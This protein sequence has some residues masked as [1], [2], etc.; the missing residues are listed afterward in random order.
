MYKIFQFLNINKTIIDKRDIRALTL[1]NG[2]KI[3][4]VSDKN[5]INSSCSVAVNAGYLQDNINHQ[6]TAHFL[7]HL[8]FMG[9]ENFK[10]KNEFH[11]YIQSCNGME[12][13][14][15]S[16]NTTCYFI[17]LNS[18]FLEKGI[19]ML[20]CFFKKPMFYEECIKS[21]YNIINSEHQKNILSDSWICDNLFKQF[22]KKSLKYKNFGTGNH[23]SLKNTTQK[24][25]FEYFNRY[26]TTDN[27]NVCI[28]DSKNIEE[29]I[30]LYVPYFNFQNKNKT[31]NIQKQKLDLINDNLLIYKS[32][33][34]F[35]IINF[36]FIFEYDKNDY[37]LLTFINYLLSAN[38]NNSLNDC[39][40]NQ[41]LILNLNSNIEYLYDFDALVTLNIFAINDDFN[42]ICKIIYNFIDYLLNINE[43]D[44]LLI[45][46]NY[47]KHKLLF[48]LY[49]EN[50]NTVDVSNEIIYNMINNNIEN[51]II[52]NDIIKI[53][54]IYEKFITKM[55]NIDIK[56]ITNINNNNLEFNQKSKYYNAEYCFSN[57][58]INLNAQIKNFNLLNLI[59]FKNNNI[60]CNTMFK[61]NTMTQI[62]KYENINYT[63]CNINNKYNKPF[64]S[65]V[66]I[67]KNNKYN[68]SLNKIII[69]LYIEICNNALESYLNTS[70][71]YLMNFKLLI[72]NND[73][74]YNFVGLDNYIDEFV[75]KIINIME[76]CLTKEQ[77]ILTKNKMIQNIQNFKHNSPYVICY[78]YLSH[79]T[80]NEIFPN[81]TCDYIKLM[82]Y[83]SF[84]NK[85]KKL[86]TCDFTN[87]LIIGKKNNIVE[88]IIKS[89]IFN[90]FTK[91]IQKSK[92]NNNINININNIN[93]NNNFL[94]YTLNKNEFNTNEI[95]NCLLYFNII[96]KIDVNDTN[97]II[98]YQIICDIVA[99][100]INEPL[101]HSVRTNDKIGYVVKCDSLMSYTD[102]NIIFSIY[103]LIQSK[104]DVETIKKS[105]NNFNN[106][107]CV[108]N[109]DISNLDELNNMKNKYDSIIKSKINEYEKD[110]LNIEDEM[111][112]YVDA[113]TLNMSNLNLKKQFLEIIEK[114]T[115]NEIIL[116]ITNFC[117]TN[118]YYIT[119]DCN[120]KLNKNIIKNN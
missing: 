72:Y 69:R 6:G 35:K 51:S 55:K 91:N 84:I 9:N 31:N 15:T 66:I 16:D 102:N 61:N 24:D 94:D 32:I 92:N 113:I 18:M 43:S 79:L 104:F 54:N 68:N 73:I 93:I 115:F 90:K 110:N 28:I 101:H 95:N 20:S 52:D 17:S 25:M 114:I 57:F 30:N 27:L 62:K 105:I 98:K 19:E 58:K 33:S 23:E 39:L 44:L 2:M 118:N 103:Y 53:D 10:N 5:I 97:N 67:K 7:E 26:Y 59:L 38:C 37:Q 77:F 82:E 106:Y 12:N 46:E 83:D 13:A 100:L 78:K 87:L 11:E 99:K 63:I 96:Q 85:C 120:N 40:K 47:K 22:M 86:I 21:E 76:T 50:N 88:K 14:Y 80:S 89:N 36:Y 60:I 111:K 109:K 119:I 45:Y 56:I 75:M 4:L 65:I 64:T 1:T 3:I 41:N 108:K 117:E 81:D 42:D 29:M 112:M 49:K 8:L 107:F 71:N 74:V 70:N 116:I 34:S 48:G